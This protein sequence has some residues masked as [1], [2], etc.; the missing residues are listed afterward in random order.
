LVLARRLSELIVLAI[1]GV[2]ETIDVTGGSRIE[3]RGS[4]FETRF[5]DDYMR[6][7]PGRA[8]Q[9]LRLHQGGARHF[10]NVGIQRHQQQRH[11]PSARR[12]RERLSAR[13]DELHLPVQPA[14]RWPNR[15]AMSFRKCRCNLVGAS[16]EFGNIQ[17]AVVN[18]L[19][20]QGGEPGFSR[21]LSYYGQPVRLTAQTDR[22]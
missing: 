21:D 7:I 9:P 4:G 2:T 3:A 16:A 1:G 22:S 8:L 18:V 12:E 13:R 6:A 15:A 19:Y 10:A 5:G 20:P 11:R 17:G 14:A